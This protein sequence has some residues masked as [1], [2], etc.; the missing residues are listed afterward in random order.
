MIS[1]VWR[2]YNLELKIGISDMLMI[3]LVVKISKSILLLKLQ[4]LLSY[5]LHFFCY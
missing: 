3:S 2:L 1:E 4:L 5:E